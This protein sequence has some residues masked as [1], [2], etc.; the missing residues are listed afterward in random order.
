MFTYIVSMGR[1]ELDRAIA[2]LK[3]QLKACKEN[4]Q[5]VVDYVEK[6]KNRRFKE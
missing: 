4:K 1:T 6:I 5:K 2:Q 3:R